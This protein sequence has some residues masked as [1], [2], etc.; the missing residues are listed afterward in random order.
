[1]SSS[2][3][4]AIRRQAVV[5]PDGSLFGYAVRADVADPQDALITPAAEE[6]LADEQYAATDFGQLV[7]DRPVVL[8]IGARM[9]R[10]D[11]P[12]PVTPRA[13]VAEVPAA[14]ARQDDADE[15]LAQLRERGAGLALSGYAATP[16]QDA[17]LPFADLVKVDLRSDPDRLALLVERIHE[18]GAWAVGEHADTRERASLAHELSMDLMQRALVRRQDPDE[19]RAV[20]AGEVQHLQLLRLLSAEVPDHGKVVRAVSFDPELSMRVL[21]VVNASATGLSH[22]IDSLPRAVGLLGPR[23]LSAL[24]TSMVVSGHPAAV[25]VLWSVITRALACWRLAGDDDAAY[26]VGM[27]SGLAGALDLSVDSVVERSGVSAELA[28]GLRGGGGFYG[29]VLDAVLA[30]EADDTAAVVATGFDP[31]DVARIYLHVMPEALTA[32]TAMGGERA[33]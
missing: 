20:S 24:V 19:G 31:V 33:A 25:D 3:R 8:R 21:Q 6:R 28:R 30:H 18:G 10:G 13:L 27:L 16:A 23:R 29:G 9:L 26:T 15:L 14:V 17:L 1:M 32:A 2:S 11:L 12:L 7:G 4:V 22:H 5:H